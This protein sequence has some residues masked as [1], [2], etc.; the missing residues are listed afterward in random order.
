MCMYVILCIMCAPRD[1]GC[2]ANLCAIELE[3]RNLVMI[4]FEDETY[5]KGGRM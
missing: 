2:N 5:F 1:L 3:I 4:S